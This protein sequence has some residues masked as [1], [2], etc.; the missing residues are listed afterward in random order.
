MN[1]IC[2]LIFIFML[3]Y[4]EFEL[5]TRQ[6]YGVLDRWPNNKKKTFKNVFLN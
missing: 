6:M 2:S 1:N 3:I 4:Y 5:G